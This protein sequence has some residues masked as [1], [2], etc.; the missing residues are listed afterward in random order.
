MGHIMDDLVAKFQELKNKHTELIAE[1]VKY[2]ARREQL[3]S[4]I[5]NIQS[6]YTSYDL[7]TVKSVD[8]IIKT[9]TNQ[10]ENEL[11]KISE[12]YDKIKAAQ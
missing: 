2:E 7:S 11:K 10:L 8:K 6:K 9:L 4:E 5:E 3:K 12:Q 1:R